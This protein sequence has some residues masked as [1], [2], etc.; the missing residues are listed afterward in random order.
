MSEQEYTLR[1]RKVS[2]ALLYSKR[3]S[4]ES[5]LQNNNEKTKNMKK[6]SVCQ[7]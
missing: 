1:V 5:N 4:N 6:K 7:D 2:I 3:S